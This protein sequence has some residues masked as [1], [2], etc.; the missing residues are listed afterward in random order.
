MLEYKNNHIFQRKV[1][2]FPTEIYRVDDEST[3][4]F[5]LMYTLLQLGLGQLVGWQDEAENSESLPGT[6]FNDLDA[7]FSF[8]GIA[9]NSY[10]LYT[11]DPYHDQLTSDQWNEVYAKDALFRIR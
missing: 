2:N 3:H 10:E 5:K 7:F 6:M 8:L 11:F 9:R 4:I 1:L